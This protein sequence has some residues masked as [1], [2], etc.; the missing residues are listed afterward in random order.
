VES[1]AHLSRSGVG[2][3]GF[4][5]YLN[6]GPTLA[7]R[8][9]PRSAVHLGRTGAALESKGCA[10]AAHALFSVAP[11]AAAR[12][13]DADKFDQWLE[14]LERLC[15]DAPESLPALL[16]RVEGILRELDVAAFE[17][18]ALA[19]IRAAG[20]DPER[21]Q[22]FFAFADPRAG[23]WLYRESG[24][25]EFSEVERRLKT[26]LVALWHLWAPIRRPAGKTQNGAPRRASF[27]GRLIRMPETFKG[28]S[29]QQAVDLFRAA[30]AHVGAHIVFSGEK[31]PVGSL[32]PIQLALVSL[33][34]DAR[35][36]H[37]AMREFPGL[38]RLWLPFHIADAGGATTAPGL[39]L[40]LA[41]ALI[42]PEYRDE[43]AWVCKGR[44]LFFD[45]RKDW[46]DPAVSR[47]IGGLLG[48]DLGQLRIQF[49]ARTYVVEPPYRDDNLGLWDFGD[50]N[51]PPMEEMDTVYES[52]RMERQ[53]EE[54]RKRDQAEH[55]KE[56]SEE[57]G[58][59]L[60]RYPEW[61]YVIAR[62]RPEWTSV[63]DYTP[64]VDRPGKIDEI[65]ERYPVLVNRITALIRSAKVSRPVKQRRQHEGD[66]LDLDACVE[67][68]VSRR[69]REAPDPRIYST[70]VRKDR[71]LTVLLLID[72]SESTNDRVQGGITNV[73][74]LERDATAVLAHAMTELDDPF[75]IR[76]FSSDGREDVRYFR[77]KDFKE[78]YGEA[79]KSRLAGLSGGLSTR[80][81][82]AIRHAGRELSRQSN[83]RRLLLVITDGEPSDTDVTDE[84][85]LVEDAR[86]AVASL[87]HLGVD[88]FCVGLDG[89][90]ES[91]LGRIFG[92][93]NV[94][95]IDRLERLPDKLTMLYFKLTK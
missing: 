60:A 93:H 36:E 43:D 66:R 78:P 5:A 12:L 77:I 28:F 53:I 48:N 27:D 16:D 56:V 15:D 79:A 94:L 51:Q 74:S 2:N 69:R 58:I 72:V 39:M 38:H 7:D 22:K 57:V 30:V 31:F 54:E 64:R 47:T 73:L 92:R 10:S 1:C 17:A 81:G 61:D 89:G 52:V 59:P 88:A 9:G 68:A 76:A 42:D 82:A 14:V 19:G 86:K 71:D 25:T 46:Q 6:S 35:V 75:A 90:G 29:G 45:A 33:I 13:G 65:L 87:S 4:I 50:E 85:Y 95:L 67:A 80:M 91:Y 26:Y 23:L 20:G 37:L 70:V 62:D 32:K 41:R 55:V 24:E 34:E 83:H 11:K 63:L 84:K 3:A 40:R 21:R 18:W 8:L 44:R 49:N